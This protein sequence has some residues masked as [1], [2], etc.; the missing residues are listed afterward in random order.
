MVCLFDGQN[1]DSGKR[2]G[3]GDSNEKNV[4][5]LLFRF[6]S[7]GRQ[8]ELCDRRRKMMWLFVERSSS[9]KKLLH[10]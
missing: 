4:L 2:Q 10:V 3:T 7:I 5:V 9:S 6:V 1:G 8:D